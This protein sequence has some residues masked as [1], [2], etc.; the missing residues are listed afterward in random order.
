MA[1]PGTVPCDRVT[2]VPRRGDAAPRYWS[3]VLDPLTDLLADE[4]IVL[5]GVVL[6]VG[7]VI[8]SIRVRGVSIGPAGALFAGLAAS[9]LDERLVIP[10]I[11]GI[12]GLALFTY[13]VGLAAGPQLS[14]FLRPSLPILGLVSL[15]LAA[16]APVAG[17]LGH[18]LGLPRAET[19][20][21]YAGSLTNTPALAA[22][23]SLLDA[24]ERGVP[25][26]GYALA[27]PYGVIGML[28]AV[29]VAARVVPSV[30]RSDGLGAELQSVSVRVGDG[31]ELTVGEL[32]EHHRNEVRVSRV[33]RGD[34]QFV[35]ARG[36]RLE[37]GDV[38]AVTC[39]VGL[40][41]AVIAG[42]GDRQTARLTDDRS[43]L[44]FRRMV[45]SNP[46]VVGR[47]LASL[48]L[49][50][51]HGATI[52]RVRRGETDLL[53]NLDLVLEPG[54]R[55]R[56]VA[57]PD[58]MGPIAE[59][60]GDNERR[61]SEFHPRGF[62]I[63]LLLGLLV[64]LIPIPVPG[65]GTLEL[66]SAGGP[67]IVG[68]LL[69]WQERTGPLV[70]QAPHGVSYT[71]RQLGS[72]LFL[73][74]AGTSGGA[75]LRAAI[76]EGGAWKPFV[77]GL[78]ITSLSAVALLAIGR[79]RRIGPA[80]TAGLVAGAQ[81]QPAVLAFATDRSS[82]PSLDLTYALVLPAAMVTKILAAQLLVLI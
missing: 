36:D 18:L 76:E 70:W 71:I 15:L 1:T 67:L 21:L 78:V 26:V 28:L 59:E 4:P 27:Y 17:L 54:D 30:Q 51:R 72:L 25:V 31:R 16:L 52:T 56:V 77:G 73:G 50:H 63:G 61:V 62:T 37:A 80:S 43:R 47:P 3:L 49:T 55:V 10:G 5:L 42:L 69:G 9:A 74:M 35:P 82:D 24:D 6:A 20:G 46:D 44:D 48:R 13:C 7:A 40:V 79:W 66:G 2:D 64:G 39:P 14:R 29:V 11:V 34:R 68:L 75:A 53:A 32:Q 41:N 33:Q 58:R 19:A 8:G 22:T 38:V 45:V 65:I 57:P 81:T 12:V 60:L 23:Q